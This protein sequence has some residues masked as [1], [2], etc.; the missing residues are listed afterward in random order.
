MTEESLVLSSLNSFLKLIVCMHHILPLWSVSG[1]YAYLYKLSK[2]TGCK[3]VIIL[4]LGRELS[5]D[6]PPSD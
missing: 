4:S 2:I 5:A 3:R 1:M 6:G